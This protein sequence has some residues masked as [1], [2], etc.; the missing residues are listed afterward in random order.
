MDAADVTA[1]VPLKALGAAK[2]RLAPALPPPERRGL[3]ARM[4]G[5]VCDACRASP[6]VRSVVLLAGDDEAARVADGR[7]VAVRRSPQP[8]LAAALADA[9]EAY[10][11]TA[12]TL[13]V[14]ADLP[15]VGADELTALV[16]A[17]G[18]GPAVVLAPTAD[19]GTGALL[20]RP[21]GVIRTAFGPGSAAAHAAATPA[22]VRLVRW[23]SPTLGHDV[24]EPADLPRAGACGRARGR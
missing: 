18:E 15:G 2:S 12:A 11:D 19:G 16:A 5:A 20:R 13:V 3:A 8:G 22:D 24:D 23:W 17:A 21:P 7:G 4:A 14:A 6:A 9:D 10:D 1:L